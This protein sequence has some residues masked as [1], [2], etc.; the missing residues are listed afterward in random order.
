MKLSKNTRVSDE[1]QR[2]IDIGRKRGR[3]KLKN[4]INNYGIF[5]YTPGSV[6]KNMLHS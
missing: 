6:E 4:V 5:I 2:E 3:E 1:V